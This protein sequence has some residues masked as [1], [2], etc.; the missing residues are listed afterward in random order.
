M[1]TARERIEAATLANGELL[2]DPR[3]ASADLEATETVSRHAAGG[4]IPKLCIGQAKR[5]FACIGLTRSR[6]DVNG[7]THMDGSANLCRETRHEAR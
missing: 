7:D 2:V 4:V 1:S 3:L 6:G 5:R